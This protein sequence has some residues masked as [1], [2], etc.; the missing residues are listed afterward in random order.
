MSRVVRHK[1]LPDGL[2]KFIAA[3]FVLV[4]IISLGVS[5]YF[6]Q[7]TADFK[8]SAISAEGTVV[9]FIREQRSSRR[10]GHTTRYYTVYCPLITFIDSHGQ[11]QQLKARTCSNPADY[12]RGEKVNI[13][14]PENTPEAAQ[15]GAFFELYGGVLISLLFAVVFSL[16]GGIHLYFLVYVDK[17]PP[18]SASANQS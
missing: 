16:V 14:Y 8:A 17:K 18:A 11:A 3:L 12:R 7:K 9:D 10:E 2:W 13:L 1:E 6:W 15:L 4:G 5:G